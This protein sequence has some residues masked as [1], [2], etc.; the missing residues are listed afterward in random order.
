MKGA[1]VMTTATPTTPSK[2][3]PRNLDDKVQKAYE[4]NRKRIQQ[5][6]K[7]PSSLELVK[8]YWDLFK[9]A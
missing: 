8:A 7:K 1:I 5:V 3:A 6:K 9:A 2:D 4:E